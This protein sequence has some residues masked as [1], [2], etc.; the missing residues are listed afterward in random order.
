MGAVLSSW[1]DR[2]GGGGATAGDIDTERVGVL[3]KMTRVI[4]VAPAFQHWWRE[5]RFGC[6]AAVRWVDEA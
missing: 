6:R 2:C 4:S 5:L 1:E 3:F